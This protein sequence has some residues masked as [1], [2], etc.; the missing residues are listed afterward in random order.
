MVSVFNAIKRV[1]RRHKDVEVVY[2]VHLSPNV[3][4]LPPKFWER[5]N[6]YT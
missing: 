6:E 3:Q 1:V 2:P 5:Q 4:K